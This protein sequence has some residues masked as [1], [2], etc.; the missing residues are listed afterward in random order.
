M[1]CRSRADAGNKPQQ[2]D[3]H[4]KLSQNPQVQLPLICP[5]TGRTCCTDPGGRLLAG[6]FSVSTPSTS[7]AASCFEHAVGRWVLRDNRPILLQKMVPRSS[8]H[9]LVV[10]LLTSTCYK[11]KHSLFFLQH[12]VCVV[13]CMR[14]PTELSLRPVSYTGQA[15]QRAF[16]GAS[17]SGKTESAFENKRTFLFSVECGRND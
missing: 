11:N 6:S 7:A 1:V 13:L 5:P 2:F 4:H 9:L 16:G 15:W 10:L 12:V 8:C 17:R 14:R 3:L